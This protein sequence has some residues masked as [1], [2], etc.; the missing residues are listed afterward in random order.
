MLFSSI[1]SYSQQWVDRSYSYDS[2]LNIVYGTATN[3]LGGTDTLKMD[4]YLPK[5]SSSVQNNKKPL[6][7]WIHGGSFLE[8]SKNDAS[9]QTLCK[10]FAQRGYITAS[11]SYRL[12]FISDDN[13]WTCNYPNYNCFFAGDS[14]EWVRA[15]YR[16]IQDGKGALRYL[17]NR[18]EQFR[19]DTANIFVAGESAGAFL[20]LGI[21]LMDTST[22]KP[23]EAFATVGLPLP[24][25]NN[26]ECSY[27]KGKIFEGTQIL[28]PDLG[29]IEGNI[30]PSTIQ[31]TI[32]GVG[33]IF[34]GMTSDLL[35]LLPNG[36]NKPAIYSFHQPCDIV[37]PIDSAT[38]YWGINWCF[39]NGYNCNAIANT[40]IKIYGARAFSGW[41]TANGY[42]YPTKNEFTTTS[43]PF[44]FLFGQGSCADQITTP[45]HAYD[46][47]TLRENNLA[48]YFA[49]F[50]STSPLCHST[51][52]SIINTVQKNISIYPN[53]AKNIINVLAADGIS[54]S[55]YSIEII[56]LNGKILFSDINPNQSS[57]Y[58]IP[59]HSIS[60]Q[61]ILLLKLTNRKGDTHIMKFFKY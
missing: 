54:E 35:K 36:K 16:G 10:K 7:M 5:C 1:N 45:C 33:N 9:I 20:A 6:L 28:R 18:H 8:G 23:K 29:P 11:I 47:P 27:N 15:M 55:I 31:Y 46:S 50:V 22:E 56:D 42:G 12:G 13:S 49:G 21:A 59:L 14:A 41:N 44:N 39:T 58:Y 43:F 34:G 24:N 4:V 53:P 37:V 60:S 25:I 52:T 32:K 17:I 61:G 19:I 48:A 3:F 38:I 57:N 26:R 40:N 30:E 51:T 2:I